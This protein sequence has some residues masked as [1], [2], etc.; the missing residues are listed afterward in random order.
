MDNLPQHV[1]VV[2]PVTKSLATFPKCLARKC[3][4]SLVK[5][6]SRHTDQQGLKPRQDSRLLAVDGSFCVYAFQ[7]STDNLLRSDLQA[8]MVGTGGVGNIW[9]DTH[10]DQLGNPVASRCGT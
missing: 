6:P 8:N 1:G 2:K 3:K 9:Q 5:K 10:S 7:G 4:D